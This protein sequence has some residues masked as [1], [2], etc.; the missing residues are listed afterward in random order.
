MDWIHQTHVRKNWQ[1]LVK[2]V[3]NLQ[4]SKNVENLPTNYQLLKIN[5]ARCGYMG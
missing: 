2:T 4:V 5:S 1:A 3:M